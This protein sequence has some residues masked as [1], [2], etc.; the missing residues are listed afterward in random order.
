METCIRCNEGTMQ[1]AIYRCGSVNYEVVDLSGNVLKTFS[2]HNLPADD[3]EIGSNNAC[4]FCSCG[5]R[6][7]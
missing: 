4:K 3:A 1:D 2:T 5:K 7:S 6:W